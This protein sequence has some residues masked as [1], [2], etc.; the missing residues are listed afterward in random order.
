[1]A[2]ARTMKGSVCRAQQSDDEALAAFDADQKQTRLWV[3]FSHLALQWLFSPS[4]GTAEC[5][6]HTTTDCEWQSR[7]AEGCGVMLAK[8]V[9][10]TRIESQIGF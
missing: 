2:P 8:Q 6:A 10:D 9:L 4:V 3:H 7:K 5:H 1:L